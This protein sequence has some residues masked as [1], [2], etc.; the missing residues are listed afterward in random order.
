MATLPFPATSR[1]TDFTVL[2]DGGPPPT[3]SYGLDPFDAIIGVNFGSESIVDNEA[4]PTGNGDVEGT[5]SAYWLTPFDGP[6]I[7]A[8]GRIGTVSASDFATLYILGD[9]SFYWVMWVR[10]SN[11]SSSGL[12]VLNDSLSVLGSHTGVS[13][14]EGDGL[15]FRTSTGRIKVYIEQAGGSDWGNPVLT[16]SGLTIPTSGYIGFG[17]LGAG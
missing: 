4:V 14:N 15:G 1:L 6:N 12:Y 8:W 3:A 2:S 17:T 10:D 7:E 11:P 13:F 9:G 5:G 16:V